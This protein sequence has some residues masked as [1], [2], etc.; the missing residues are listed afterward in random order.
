MCALKSTHAVLFASLQMF[1]A[2]SANLDI[3]QMYGASAI[4]LQG[5]EMKHKNQASSESISKRPEVASEVSEGDAWMN[6]RICWR[7]E[8][9]ADQLPSSEEDEVA[10]HVNTDHMVNQVPDKELRRREKVVLFRV[11]GYCELYY[12]NSK[13]ARQ[14]YYK[15]NKAVAKARS[16]ESYKNSKE[17][18]Q[19]YYKEYYEN[20]KQAY[21]GY[22]ENN[23]EANRACN[24]EWHKNN[25]EAIR[26][27][28]KEHYKN[29]KE[30]FQAYHKEYRENNKEALQARKKEYR[31]NNKE[32]LQAQNKEYRENNKEYFKEY[33]ENNKQ[34][35][36]EYRENNKE[37]IRAR[38]KEY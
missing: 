3:A 37:A 14:A 28:K 16:K 35:F 11:E 5:K 7:T 24:K 1:S 25:K 6:P 22:R 9:H 18:R 12:K 38:K 31:E 13:E 36:K 20:N 19:A 17:A 23:K 29:N 8:L 27:R 4:R 21:K 26:A 34:A 10:Q 33:Y 30:A 32:A 2:P 15:N